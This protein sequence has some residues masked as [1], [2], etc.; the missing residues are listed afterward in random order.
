MTRKRTHHNFRLK[1]IEFPPFWRNS[2]PLPSDPLNSLRSQP[3]TKP[4]LSV[5]FRN[6]FS[7]VFVSAQETIT[8]NTFGTK[9]KGQSLAKK[10]IARLRLKPRISPAKCFCVV[11][12]STE[13]VLK[14]PHARRES[15]L[16]IMFGLV[17]T[18]MYSLSFALL[19][20]GWAN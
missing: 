18:S 2:Q 13:A 14:L 6:K 3:T 8:G 7:P 20:H 12:D 19:W 5:G 9:R 1:Q 17:W 15:I 16:C 10:E 11:S 4:C